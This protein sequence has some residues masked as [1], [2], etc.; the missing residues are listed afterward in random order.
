MRNQFF[1]QADE[2][3]TS[4]KSIRETA[5]TGMKTTMDYYNEQ[6]NRL[7]EIKRQ[8]IQMKPPIQWAQNLFFVF[9]EVKYAYR[10]DVAGCA[11]V[12]NETIELTESHLSIE[13]Y[14]NE[15]DNFLKFNVEIE[16]WADVNVTSLIWEYQPVGKHYIS[17]QKENKP[18]RWRQLQREGDEKPALLKLWFEKHQKFHYQ[19]HEHEDDDITDYEGHNLIDVREEGD[20]NEMSWLFPRRGPSPIPKKKKKRCKEGKEGDKCRKRQAKDRREAKQRQKDE[21]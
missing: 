1:K 18:G 19:L 11:T 2:G 9:V 13:A 10:H 14:C 8:P 4:L 12:H 20:P 17:F 7:Y 6:Q 21:L 3:Q 16:L 15:Q 5:V